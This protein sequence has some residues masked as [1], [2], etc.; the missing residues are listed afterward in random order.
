MILISS[1]RLSFVYK[2]EQMNTIDSL[3]DIFNVN[4]RKVKGNVISK[5]V[6]N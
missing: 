5:Q 6:A 4:L 3:L 1:K 2:L